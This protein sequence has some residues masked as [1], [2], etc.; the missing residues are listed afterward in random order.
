MSQTYV[1]PSQTPLTA[2][3]STNDILAFKAVPSS[4]MGASSVPRSARIANG[5]VSPQAVVSSGK[6][7]FWRDPTAS[8]IGR[9]VDPPEGIPLNY[10]SCLLSCDDDSE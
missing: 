7:T 9:Q 1:S 10:N 6:Y 3:S 4:D 5:T 2:I 8:Q